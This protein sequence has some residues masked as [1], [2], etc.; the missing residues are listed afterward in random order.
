[1]GKV[2][3]LRKEAKECA[4]FREHTMSKFKTIDVRHSVAKCLDCGM[5]VTVNTD[6]MPNEIDIGGEAVALNCKKAQL[7]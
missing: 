5:E 1:M 2:E 4:A 7:Q 6:P 3:R